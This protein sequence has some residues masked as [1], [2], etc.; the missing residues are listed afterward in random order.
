MTKN[1]N[2][3]KNLK[4][5]KAKVSQFCEKNHIRQFSFFG[6]VLR[7]DFNDKS[8]IDVLVEFYNTVEVGLFELYD[9]EQELSKLFGGRKV[10]INTKN[11]LSKY[12]R[13]QVIK[14]M[15]IQYDKTR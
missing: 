10:D 13:K 11:S 8:D 3:I 9:M 4:A 6:S 14:E 12:F 15:E 7:D 2:S 1:K 5:L